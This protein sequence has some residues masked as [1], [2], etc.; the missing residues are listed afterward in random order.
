[1]IG[2]INSSNPYSGNTTVVRDRPDGARAPAARPELPDEQSR[3]T[4]P[5]PAGGEAPGSG[6]SLAEDT[7]SYLRRVQARSAAQDSQLIPFR[8]EDIPMANQRA[9][10]TFA[11]VASQR[12]GME[13]FDAE[14]A[15]IDIRV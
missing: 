3:D 11:A 15:G 1:M 9:L 13:G 5:S 4:R 2:G 8:A 10:E 14:L 7:Q 6:V 12:E